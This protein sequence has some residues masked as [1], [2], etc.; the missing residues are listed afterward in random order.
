MSDV[1]PGGYE[2]TPENP[3]ALPREVASDYTETVTSLL[4][5]DYVPALYAG[6]QA[7]KGINYMIICKQRVVSP[8]GLEYLVAV[9]PR[10]R[11]WK[12]VLGEFER[13]V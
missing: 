6:K 5:A 1:I 11:G 3:C 10:S 7:V 8:D 4:G 2:F 13:I 9:D 12:V